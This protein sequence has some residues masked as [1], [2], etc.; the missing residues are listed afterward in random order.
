MNRKR[1]HAGEICQSV[2]SDAFIHKPKIAR[3]LTV[4]HSV[5]E[6]IDVNSFVV[7]DILCVASLHALLVY[8]KGFDAL[9]DRE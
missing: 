4:L 6:N 8:E 5:S 2:S 3:N 7:V 1:K 9:G